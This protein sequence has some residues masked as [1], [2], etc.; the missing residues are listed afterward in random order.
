MKLKFLKI[1]NFLSIL[2]RIKNVTVRDIYYDHMIDN[3]DCDDYYPTLIDITYSD[4]LGIIIRKRLSD[5]NNE[6]SLADV[7]SFYHSC[8][9]NEYGGLNEYKKFSIYK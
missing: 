8:S 7:Y 6:S 2:L 5:K 3:S 1:R 9:I 4:L